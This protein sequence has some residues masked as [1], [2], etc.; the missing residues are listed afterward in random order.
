M[1]PWNGHA[2]GER[3]AAAIWKAL[4]YP[5]RK[6][7]TATGTDYCDKCTDDIGPIC[8]DKGC[9]WDIFQEAKEVTNHA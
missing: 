3:A 6:P 7:A 9:L 5:F 1:T 2:A 8:D 4:T